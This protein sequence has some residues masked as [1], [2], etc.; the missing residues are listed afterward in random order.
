MIRDPAK[1]IPIKYVRFSRK[2]YL[3]LRKYGYLVLVPAIPFAY[4]SPHLTFILAAGFFLWFFANTYLSPKPLFESVK[5][6][7]KKK[8]EV[9]PFLFIGND[10]FDF[11]VEIPASS[12]KQHMLLLGSTGSGKTSFLRRMI[13]TQLRYGGGCCFIDGKSDVAD[14]YQIVFSEICHEDREEDFYLINFLNPDQSHT[15]NPFLY[16]DSD[17]LVEVLNGLLK[18]A[19]GDNVYWQERGIVMLRAYL[20]VLVWLRDHRKDFILDIRKVNEMM[21]LETFIRLAIDPSIPDI[22]VSGKPV[23]SR[24]ALYLS[25]LNPN[26]EKWFTKEMSAEERAEAVKQFGYAV[27]QWSTA[28]DLVSGVYGKIFCTNSPDVDIRDI[29]I[30]N[31]ILYVLLPALKQSPQTLKA[32][33]R[34]CL[35][36]Y[37]IVFSEL[38][39]DTVIGKTKEIYWKVASQKPDPPFLLIL[40]EYG[41][42]AVDGFDTILAQAR[43]TGVSVVISV[44]EVASLYKVNDVEAK[45]LLNNTRVKICLRVDDPDT[46]KYYVERAGEDWSFIPSVKREIGEF[47]EGAW[48]NYE[49]NFSY[50]KLSRID[51]LDLYGLNPGQGYILDGT[52]IRKFRFTEV[53]PPRPEKMRLIRF[54][55]DVSM[56]LHG[57]LRKLFKHVPVLGVVINKWKEK[58]LEWL[59]SAQQEFAVFELDEVEWAV[60]SDFD[61]RNFAFL[62]LQKDLW[63]AMYEDEGFLNYGVPDMNAWE[64]FK[65]VLLT[66]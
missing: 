15:F 63:R 14:M 18:E 49:G 61:E 12:M 2:T 20:S 31:K 55:K 65:K 57:H 58:E 56:V 39:G 50:Q 16:G 42:Y 54:V 66:V 44:Q 38:I 9:I 26:W 1:K 4:F 28:F 3:M 23:K 52:E 62:A 25:S 21:N 24:L 60:D 43:S 35:S 48:G 41:S 53:K 27:Q 29:V 10:E 36:V 59:W 7:Y 51:E 8:K 46:S 45:R 34:L 47:L 17:F 30:N 6:V 64:E 19:Q 22:D 5:S 32:L 40:D 33:G 37:R 13:Q 11:P